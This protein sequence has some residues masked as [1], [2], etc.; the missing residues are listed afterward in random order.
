MEEIQ[1]AFRLQRGLLEKTIA[2]LK[3]R[4]AQSADEHQK[5]YVK[6]MKV[7]E[8]VFQPFE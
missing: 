3:T 7:S 4:L 2:S 5:I 8:G 1:K 6:L